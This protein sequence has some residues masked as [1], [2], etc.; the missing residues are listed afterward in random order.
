MSHSFTSRGARKMEG[1]KAK[2]QP[3]APGGPISPVH[4]VWSGRELAPHPTS[5]CQDPKPGPARP[6]LTHTGAVVGPQLEAW[7]ALAAEGAR[8]VHA[9]VLAVAVA[10]LVYIWDGGQRAEVRWDSSWLGVKA[11]PPTVLSVSGRW[12]G[13]DQ[14]GLTHTPIM[15]CVW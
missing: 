2:E 4:L 6:S 8:Q 3:R 1:V 12:A 15:C 11:S 5:P 10:A 13:P 7:L 9:A 14:A